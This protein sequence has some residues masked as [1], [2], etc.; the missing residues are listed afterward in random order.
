MTVRRWFGTLRAGS[1]AA[2]AE[3]GVG[4]MDAWTKDWM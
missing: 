3:R 2:R 1:C 4:F